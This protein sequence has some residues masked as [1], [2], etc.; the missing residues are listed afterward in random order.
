MSLK[1]EIKGRERDAVEATKELLAIDGLQG[2][3]QIPNEVKREGTL[4]TIAAIVTIVGETI[5]IGEKLYQWHQ[6]NQKPLPNSTDPRTEKVLLV[7]DD[8][9]NRRLLLKKDV[10]VEQIQE[11]LKGQNK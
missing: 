7:D 10:T 9:N 3:Y 5:T 2:S 1:I 11:F 6:K 4:V 8:D